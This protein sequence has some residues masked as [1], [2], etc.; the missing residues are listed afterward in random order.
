MLST[1]VQT[2]RRRLIAVL[3]LGSVIGFVGVTIAV[4]TGVSNGIDEWVVRRTP[5]LATQ[6]GI[7]I[8]AGR[9]RRLPLVTIA[10][11]PGQFAELW[12]AAFGIEEFLAG[13][14]AI[15]GLVWVVLLFS[16]AVS[17]W[18]GTRRWRRWARFRQGAINL[19]VVAIAIFACATAMP[20]LFARV[21]PYEPSLSYPD[22]FVAAR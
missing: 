7:H 15:L 9:Y 16:I 21:S 2:V 18:P 20:P 10:S 22:I 5:T 17:S 1:T 14:Y 19:A 6:L 8:T 4:K 11:P 13:P 3:V 12:Q